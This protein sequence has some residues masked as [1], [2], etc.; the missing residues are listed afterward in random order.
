MLAFCLPALAQT[1]YNPQLTDEHVAVRGSMLKLVVPDGYQASIDYPGFEEL[2]ISA[3]IMVNELPVNY[4]ELAGVFGNADELAT[5]GMTLIS[6]EEISFHGQLADFAQVDQLANGELF[7]K[8]ILAFGDSITTYILT[9]MLPKAGLQ[10]N[11]NDV[12][13]ALLST[14]VDE[15]VVV[16]P[17]AELPFSVSVDS[18]KLQF[19]TTISSSALYTVDGNVPTESGDD[20]MLIVANSFGEVVVADR[21]AFA[22]ESLGE[23]PNVTNVALKTKQAVTIQG[24]DGVEI[25]ATA[26]DDGEETF[27]F[28]TVLFANSKY[29]RILGMSTSEVDNLE[30]FRTIANTFRLK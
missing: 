6:H 28:H 10:A 5:Q 12:K 14:V 25:T 27:I 20:T 22:L 29:Y 16:D 19:A 23:L 1:E 24:L 18:T 4:D 13:L 2:E 7:E 30:M 9:G 15:T 26:L 3:A 21:E 11:K 17:L 8:Y